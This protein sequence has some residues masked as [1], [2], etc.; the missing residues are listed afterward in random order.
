MKRIVWFS[1]APTDR[2]WEREDDVSL[3]NPRLLEYCKKESA[4][5]VIDTSLQQQT[6]RHSIRALAKAAS[7]SE[8]AMK[9]SRRGGRIRKSTAQRLEKGLRTLSARR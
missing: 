8:K 4:R 7:V 5:L 3:L 1:S 6:R 2:R 9:S